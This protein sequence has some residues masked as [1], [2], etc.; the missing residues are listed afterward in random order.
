MAE[1]KMTGLRSRAQ[2]LGRTGPEAAR[3][4]WLL[5]AGDLTRWLERQEL[6]QPSPALRTPQYDPFGEP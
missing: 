4:H 1:L 3:A 5:V 6:P 2:L